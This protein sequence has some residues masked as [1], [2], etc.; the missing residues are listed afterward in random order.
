MQKFIGLLIFSVLFF[1]CGK[2]EVQI[3]NKETLETVEKQVSLD[4]DEATAEMPELFF[5]VQIAALT[6]KNETLSNLE[7]IQIYN[8]N[9]LIKYRLGNFQT[10]REAKEYQSQILSQYKG[11]FVQA[12]KNNKPI[13]ITEALQN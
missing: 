1:S 13:H 4:V 11:A 7:N 6:N 10:Y 12:L 9:S 2:K 8:E 5:T 3:E